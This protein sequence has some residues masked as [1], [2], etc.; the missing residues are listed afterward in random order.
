VR[1]KNG[2]RAL[3]HGDVLDGII[4]VA[5]VSLIELGSKTVCERAH[6]LQKESDT[7]KVDVVLINPDVGRGLVQKGV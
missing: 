6:A 3:V 1:V 4:E 7:E 2:V 5:K